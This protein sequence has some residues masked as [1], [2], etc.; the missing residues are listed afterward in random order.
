MRVLCVFIVS[1]FRKVCDFCCCFKFLRE[2]SIKGFGNFFRFFLNYNLIYV[3]E[4]GFIFKCVKEFGFKMWRIR[5]F[6][7]YLGVGL[8]GVL[9]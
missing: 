2:S 7:C 6:R 9:F 3:G 5:R 4:E 8:F 1:F